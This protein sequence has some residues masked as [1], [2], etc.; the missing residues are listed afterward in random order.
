MNWM[1]FWFNSR[2]AFHWFWRTCFRVRI[3]I[4]RSI[5]GDPC[6]RPRVNIGW[7][8]PLLLIFLKR[9]HWLLV[10]GRSFG[11]FFQQR[12]ANPVGR[13]RSLALHSNLSYLL[14]RAIWYLFLQDLCGCLRALNLPLAE[15]R[16]MRDAVLTVSP[17]KPYLGLSDPIT[18]LTTCPEWKPTRMW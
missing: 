6:W 17:N 15:R 7:L 2:R 3:S 11:L 1:W 13:H 4:E 5:H 16:S 18:L 9:N 14:E 8:S 10:K 12:V